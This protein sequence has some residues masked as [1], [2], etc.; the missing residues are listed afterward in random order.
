[1]HGI[2]LDHLA[3][4]T[5]GKVDDI[6]SILKELSADL[7][8]IDSFAAVMPN[9][10]TMES[11]YR[12]KL[13]RKILREISEEITKS[14][15]AVLLLNQTRKNMYLKDTTVGGIS[16]LQW[17]D[18]RVQLKSNGLIRTKLL[19]VGNSVLM[20]ILDKNYPGKIKKITVPLMFETGYS[21]ELDLLDTALSF[22]V[23][24]REGAWYVYNDIS[25]G[26]G[27]LASAH[28]LSNNSKIF[29]EIFHNTKK[30]AL[31]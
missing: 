9:E 25:L 21:K 5:L 27:R 17:A 8:I 6:T 30:I 11:E 1:M 3:I 18:L 23:I 4:C 2:N 22:S 13:L 15:T 16:V 12:Y 28:Y 7:V 19:P 31:N 20:E 26:K 10:E 24:E 14:N 29:A